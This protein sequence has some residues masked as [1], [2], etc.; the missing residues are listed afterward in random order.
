MLLFGAVVSVQAQTAGNINGNSGHQGSSPQNNARKANT[1][2]LAG[3]GVP[4][5]KD[6]EQQGRGRKVLKEKTAR[7]ADPSVD[8]RSTVGG[9]QGGSSGQSQSKRS[10]KAG[11]GKNA[12]TS[13][14]NSGTRQ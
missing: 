5:S 13:P 1:S 8:T 4:F 6:A 7:T 3:K 12:G 11:T 2:Q 14:G 9:Q 10:T